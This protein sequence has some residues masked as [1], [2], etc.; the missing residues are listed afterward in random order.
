MIAQEDGFD[1]GDES[2]PI[3][4]ITSKERRTLEL[5]FNLLKY[6]NGISFEKIRRLMPEHYSN[7]T[8]ESDQRKLRRDIDVLES[9]GITIKFYTDNY[10]GEKNIYKLINSPLGQEIKFSEKELVTLSILVAREMEC[11]YSEDLLI[12]CQKIF[13]KNLQYYPKV[14]KNSE[15]DSRSIEKSEENKIFLALLKAVKDKKPIKILYYKDIPEEKKERTIDPLLILKRNSTD[16]YL[17]GYDHEKKSKRRF[18]IPKILKITEVEGDAIKNT[19]YITD[20]D[21]NHHSLAFKIHDPLKISLE[22]E[23]KLIWKIINFLN[24]HP[25]Q[26]NGSTIILTTTNYTSLYP[27]IIKEND[28]VLSTDSLEFNNGLIEYIN[29]FKKLYSIHS[30]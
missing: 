28:V 3:P 26:I 5:L 10:S 1:L 13:Q 6:S 24:P 12:A 22:C 21:L 19:S 8:M 25:Y 18:I 14:K 17:L 30:T 16:F 20:E 2:L 29:D 7:E 15:I 23:R 27:F 9:Q 4:K 11:N